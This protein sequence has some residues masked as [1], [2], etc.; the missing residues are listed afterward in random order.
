M[1]KKNNNNI[2]NIH[3]HIYKHRDTKYTHMFTRMG[4]N[5]VYNLAQLRRKQIA[6][7]KQVAATLI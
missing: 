7:R 3:D 2:I 6:C 5:R 4:T 1:H